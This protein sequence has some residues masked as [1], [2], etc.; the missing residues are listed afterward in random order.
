MAFDGVVLSEMFE[1]DKHRTI[2]FTR[3]M[4]NKTKPEKVISFVVT[5]GY[6]GWRVKLE[7]G[8]Q[9]IQASNYMRNNY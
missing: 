7:Q 3:G 2:S 1:K 9:K 5:S 6:E 8:G 4:N